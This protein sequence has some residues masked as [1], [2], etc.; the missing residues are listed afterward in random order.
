MNPR[1][2]MYK[3]PSHIDFAP[4][5]LCLSAAGDVTIQYAVLYGTRQLCC[6]NA[7]VESNWLDVDFIHINIHGR[8]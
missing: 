3:H 2:T 5:S 8:L 4:Y 6:G 1:M 7:K